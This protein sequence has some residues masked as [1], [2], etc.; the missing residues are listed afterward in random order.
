MIRVYGPL[1][2][3]GQRLMKSVEIFEI[4]QEFP[5]FHDHDRLLKEV[6]N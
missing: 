6:G 1:E 5:V 2:I 4:F 3:E